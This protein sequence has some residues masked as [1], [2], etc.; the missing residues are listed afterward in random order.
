MGMG[1]H[2]NI[3][4]FQG[5]NMANFTKMLIKTWNSFLVYLNFWPHQYLIS[6]PDGLY[7]FHAEHEQASS[8]VPVL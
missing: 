8:C 5:G 6:L 7:Y 4:F 3:T 1:E 2:F